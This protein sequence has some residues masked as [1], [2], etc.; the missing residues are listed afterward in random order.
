MIY[1]KTGGFQGIGFAIPIDIALKVL[2]QIKDHGYVVRGWLGVEGQEVYP[3][4]F[5]KLN[6]SASKG[7]LL[8]SVDRSGPAD[9][10]GL[11]RGDIITHINDRAITTVNDIMNIIAE[12]QPGETIGI[13]G[14]RERQS[15]MTDV[16][17]GER[18]MV[19]K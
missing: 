5:K 17:L 8:T 15:F 2:Q 12:A 4:T 6:L 14:L 13:A 3:V 19:S 16:K 18:P 11:Q 9:K 1:S 10:A 7:I